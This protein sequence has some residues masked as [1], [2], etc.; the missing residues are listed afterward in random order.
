MVERLRQRVDDRIVFY[1]FAIIVLNL[2]DAFATL[3]HIANGAEEVNP[4]M[5]AVLQK[6]EVTFILTKHLIATVGVFWI[7]LH[8]TP[9]RAAA[10]LWIVLPV[11]MLLCIYQVSLF[12]IYGG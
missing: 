11:Y 6:G 1:C 10:L 2:F 9:R 8:P 12:Y 7:A 5:H 4:F 3:Q